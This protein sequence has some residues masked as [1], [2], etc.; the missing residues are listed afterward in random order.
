MT[1]TELL[2]LLHSDFTV[3]VRDAL[4]KDIRLTPAL[5]QVTRTPAF[6]KLGRIR[7]LGPAALAYPSAVHTRLDHSLGVYH[8]SRLILQRLA[9]S[10]DGALFSESGVMSFLAASLLHDIG[11]FP[12]AHALKELPLK[13]HEA[14]AGILIHEDKALNEALRK[15][16]ADPDMVSRII[17]DKKGATGDRELDCYRALLSGTLDPDKLDYLNRDAWFSGVPYGA[18]DTS[19]IIDHLLLHDGLPALEEKAI[20]GVEHVLFAK[21]LMYRTVYWNPTT[22][23]ATAMVKE[24]LLEALA[25][26]ALKPEG[27]YWLDDEEFFSLRHSVPHP[28]MQNLQDV[29]DSRLL[30]PAYERNWTKDGLIERCASGLEERM[31]FEDGLFKALSKDY[32][33][34]KRWQVVVD[35]PEPVSFEATMPIQRSDGS[36]VPFGETDLLMQSDIG[37]VFARCLRQTRV[38]VPRFVDSKKVRDLV[39]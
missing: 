6:Q 21:Y 26:G 16:G 37:S 2:R 3:S 8:L 35:I 22:R 27:L 20:A 24:A 5:Q 32:P 30:V 10:G 25:D 29:H 13:S 36:V 18:Q 14:L 19:Y 1:H 7:Q 15:T 4:W 34:L 9:E 23:S 11:H 38:F 31:T 39:Q 12:Y 28:A 17:D 33:E